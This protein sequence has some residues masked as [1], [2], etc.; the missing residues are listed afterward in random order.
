MSQ[1]AQKGLVVVTGASGGIGYEL[2]KL[3]ARD[4]YPLLLVARSG[5]KLKAFAEELTAAHGVAVATCALDLAAP[6]APSQL[7]ES[8]QNQRLPVQVLVNNAGFGDYGPFA[9]ADLAACLQMLQLNV[10]ALTHLTRLFLPGM[11]ERNVGGVLNVASLAAFQPGPLMAVYYASKAYVLHLS[12][13]LAEELRHSN[14]RVTALCPGPTAT[15]FEG[16]AGLN[17]S[18]MFTGVMD[19]RAVAEAGYTGLFRGRRIVVPG[20]WNR[21]F[22]QGYRFVPRALLAGVVRR[23]H[24]NAAAGPRLP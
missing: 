3:F 7:F 6:D 21:L 12:E 18:Q 5:D 2:C 13:A 14:V 4:G 8:A 20:M 17:V 16:R 10:V 23:A 15:G 24:M 9:E 11:L 22:A 19:A 1:V